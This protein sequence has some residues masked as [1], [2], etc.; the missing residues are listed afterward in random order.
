MTTHVTQLRADAIFDALV[1]VQ[2]DGL[3]LRE[4]RIEL[5]AVGLLTPRHNIQAVVSALTLL[6]RQLAA[7][8]NHP[9]SEVLTCGKHSM[10]SKY[11]IAT[12]AEDARMYRATR[13]DEIATQIQ[14]IAIQVETERERFGGQHVFTQAA[15]DYLNDAIRELNRAASVA[16]A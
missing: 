6:R 3:T 9:D 16:V 2:P 7:A 14:T 15:V 5:E 4:L 12:D 8:G 1:S 10:Y 11:R 13:A